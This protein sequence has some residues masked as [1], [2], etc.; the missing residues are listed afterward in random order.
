[1]CI[2]MS[3]LCITDFS[4]DF[5]VREVHEGQ[6]SLFV[7]GLQRRDES[8]RCF[9]TSARGRKTTGDVLSSWFLVSIW[10]DYLRCTDEKQA[11][12]IL[13]VGLRL[14]QPD[15]AYERPHHARNHYGQTDSSS[16]HLFA[17]RLKT[18]TFV[19]MLHPAVI[20][21]WKHLQ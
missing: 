6:R 13:L 19:S 7:R 18:E 20:L 12:F 14:V 15:A 21:S 11:V 10:E 4:E 2:C 3:L 16:V 17:L 9:V 8:E 1:M 5:K